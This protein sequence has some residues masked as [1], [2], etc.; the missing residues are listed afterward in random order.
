MKLQVGVIVALAL[1]AG[2]AAAQGTFN[3]GQQPRTFGPSTPSTPKPAG[4]FVPSYGGQ[5][6]AGQPRRPGL[7]EAP[8]APAF[9]PYQPYSGSSVY[10]APRSP[11]TGAKP[12]ETSVY[13][14]ACGSR[15]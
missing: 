10:G 11:S 13:V 7:A 15:R 6:A 9:K 14:N 8:A 1:A 2:P 3:N 4:G 12:C 5:P